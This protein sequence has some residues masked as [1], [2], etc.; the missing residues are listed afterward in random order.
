MF[1]P[2][3]VLVTLAFVTVVVAMLWKGS[4]LES[5]FWG[6]ESMAWIGGAAVVALLG[7]VL[8]L[9]VWIGGHK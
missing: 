2:I 5:D 3:W 9:G 1:I 7:A 4:T 8:A 6:L